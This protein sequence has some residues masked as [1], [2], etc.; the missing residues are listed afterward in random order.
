M[1]AKLYINYKKM[2]DS[3]KKMLLS[4][5]GQKKVSDAIISYNND[6]HLESLKNDVIKRLKHKI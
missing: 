1:F 4:K 3:N 2:V 5:E 6:K